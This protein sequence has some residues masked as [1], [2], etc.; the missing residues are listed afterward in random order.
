MLVGWFGLGVFCVLLAP[1]VWLL[2]ACLN[3][4]EATDGVE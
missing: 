1:L 3:L 4:E 2:G